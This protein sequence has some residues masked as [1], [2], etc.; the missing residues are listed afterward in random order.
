MSPPPVRDAVAIASETFAQ[1]MVR[2]PLGGWGG[3]ARDLPYQQWNAFFLLVAALVHAFAFPLHRAKT[4]APDWVLF[5][6]LRNLGIVHIIYGGFQH[7]LYAGGDSKGAELAELKLKFNPKFPA[8]AQ[9]RR[10]RFWSTLGCLQSSMYECGLM[11]LWANDLL[12]SYHREG[13]WAYPAWSVGWL[14]FVMPWHSV[15]FYFV[16]RYLHIK[17]FYRWFH[18]LHHKSY[19]PGPWSGM[20]MHPVEI[21]LYFSGCL[22]PCLLISQHPIHYLFSKYLKE[23]A[24][25]P[26]HHG[27]RAYGG[28]LNHYLHHKKF[29]CNYGGSL[30]PMDHLFGTLSFED[31]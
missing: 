17:P 5:V 14:L 22:L 8:D 28:Q 11:Y 18:S 1:R 10:D 7:L 23:I 26:G 13:F 29:E 6:V 31:N 3:W 25:A 20:S 2:G 16:H 24:P 21:A 27:F 4:L 30:V 15:H 9:H 12:P 19:N